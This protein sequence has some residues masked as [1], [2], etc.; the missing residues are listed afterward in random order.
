MGLR[1]IPSWASPFRKQGFV[2]LKDLNFNFGFN[3][4]VLHMDQRNQ[5]QN[6]IFLKKCIGFYLF[7]EINYFD[8][9]YI[10]FLSNFH[11]MREMVQ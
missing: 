4:L 11:F 3:K 1:R 7:R 8:G 5:D 2:W 10:F 9:I 6:A